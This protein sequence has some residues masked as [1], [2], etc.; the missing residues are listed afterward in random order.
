MPRTLRT[1][2]HE[3]LRQ[4]LIRKR[5]EAGLTQVELAKL[6]DVYR[7]YLAHIERGQRRVDVIEFLELA[8]AIGFDPAEAI[9]AIHAN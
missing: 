7:S 6:L 5:K 1:P 2:R 3:A 9:R 8:D 4:L